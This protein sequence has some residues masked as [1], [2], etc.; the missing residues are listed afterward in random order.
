MGGAVLVTEV[1][2]S[3]PESPI[4]IVGVILV[5]IYSRDHLYLRLV[6]ATPGTGCKDS[7]LCRTDPFSP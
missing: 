6:N 7:S 4:I 5:W 3:I 2:V 1:Q